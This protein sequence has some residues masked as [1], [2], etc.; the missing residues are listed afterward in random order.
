MKTME[1]KFKV[2][3]KQKNIRYK[4]LFLFLFLKLGE[5]FDEITTDGRDTSTV[6]TVDNGK[7]VTVQ[8]AKKAGQKST[9]VGI[10]L[11]T[12][13]YSNFPIS[14]HSRDDRA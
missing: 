3:L 10:F 6:V 4:T 12:F 8:T 7:I 5:K 9:R 13:I 14:V 2:K 1:L 11:N